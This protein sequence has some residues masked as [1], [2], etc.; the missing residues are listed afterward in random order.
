MTVFRLRTIAPLILVAVLLAGCP[1]SPVDAD[2]RYESCAEAV[3][4]GH[5]PYERGDVEYGWYADQDDDGTA[6]E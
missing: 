5:G 6:C 3:A 4:A 2:P 1:S